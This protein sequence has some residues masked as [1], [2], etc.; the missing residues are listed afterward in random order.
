MCGE[1][2]METYITIFKI[3]SQWE[4]AVW[5]RELK[6]GLCDDLEGWSGKGDRREVREGDDMGEPMAD[7]CWCYDRKLQ[8][9]VKQLSF[10]QKKIKKTNKKP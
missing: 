3:D 9:P 8:N 1:S 6:Q 4:S 5:L 2:N 7:S 10:N